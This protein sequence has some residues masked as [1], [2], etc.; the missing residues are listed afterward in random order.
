MLPTDYVT[1]TFGWDAKFVGRSQAV[2]ILF[3]CWLIS[4]MVDSDCV[5]MMLQNPKPITICLRT[6]NRQYPYRLGCMSPAA[7]TECKSISDHL[8]GVY[9]PLLSYIFSWGSVFPGDDYDG[10]P[11]GGRTGSYCNWDYSGKSFM[12]P[13]GPYRSYCR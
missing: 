12:V 4:L 8:L 2:E 10:R 3:L 7:V 1:T 5:C 6:H 13:N 11:F 9:N